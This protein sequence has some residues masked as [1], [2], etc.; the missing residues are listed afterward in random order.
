MKSEAKKK[1]KRQKKGV[2]VNENTKI[3]DRK[4]INIDNSE[5]YTSS[6]LLERPSNNKIN[7]W[8]GEWGKADMQK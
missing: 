7:Y 3:R 6:H 5:L 2:A 4:L 8:S 1:R